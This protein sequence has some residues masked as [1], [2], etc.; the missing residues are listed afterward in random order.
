MSGG[1]SVV[2][3]DSMNSGIRRQLV[4]PNQLVMGSRLML[5]HAVSFAMASAT[6]KQTTSAAGDR[7]R[8]CRQ[9]VATSLPALCPNL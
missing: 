9:A 8:P 1:N 3:S 6:A 2:K 4:S 7:G 5:W